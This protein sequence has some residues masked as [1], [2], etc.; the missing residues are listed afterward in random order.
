MQEHVAALQAE[1]KAAQAAADLEATE[2]EFMS[3]I[4][5]GQHLLPVSYTTHAS[6]PVQHALRNYLLH[7]QQHMHTDH[8]MPASKSCSESAVVSPTSKS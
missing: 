3:C 1:L 7:T 8:V 5:N 4:G 2:K 6:A